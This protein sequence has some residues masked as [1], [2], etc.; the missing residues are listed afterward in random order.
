MMEIK[1]TNEIWQDLTDS[2]NAIPLDGKT[3][4]IRNAEKKYA[5]TA[6]KKWIA[7]ED[8]IKR[9]RNPST[10]YSNWLEE[11]ENEGTD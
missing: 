3:R 5:K 6:G 8:I 2:D 10:D 11:L 9:L 4:E 7:V 1:T